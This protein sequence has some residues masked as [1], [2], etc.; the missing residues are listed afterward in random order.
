[1]STIHAFGLQQQFR[2]RLQTS[3]D[4]QIRS[5]YI[6]L[7]SRRW[8]ALRLDSLGT[9]LVLGIGLF[10]VAMRNQVDP[11]KLGVVLTYAIRTVL[12]FGLMVHY[13]IQV[14][15]CREG[16]CHFLHLGDTYTANRVVYVT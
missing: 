6:N 7:V 12:V 1:L 8:L 3:A 9:V 14:G 4:R 5:E 10:G 16:E 15:H 2:R 11:V 13:T